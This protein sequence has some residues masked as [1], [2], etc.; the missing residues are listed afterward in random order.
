MSIMITDI[1]NDIKNDF[2]INEIN[3]KFPSINNNK[4][5]DYQYVFV[6]AK[7]SYYKIFF[8]ID[9]Y[10]ANNF[11]LPSDSLLLNINAPSFEV[12]DLTLVRSLDI[13]DINVPNIQY[14]SCNVYKTSFSL[15]ISNDD[16][17]VGSI[18]RYFDLN[19]SF[20]FNPNS[21]KN[22][23]GQIGVS[24]FNEFINEIKLSKITIPFYHQN[25]ILVNNN[26]Y[27]E[28]VV[29]VESNSN[30]KI[31]L[32]KKN[33]YIELINFEYTNEPIKKLFSINFDETY[34]LIFKDVI[35]NLNYSIDNQKKNSKLQ[36]ESELGINGKNILFELNN[37]ET[38]FDES[39]KEI[40]F[41]KGNNGISFPFNTYGEYEIS[42]VMLIE[43]KPTI[44]KITNKF[45]YSFVNNNTNFIVEDLFES[46]INYEE[47]Y[48]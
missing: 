10:I 9:V 25:K 8:E 41:Q 32:T 15:D 16:F 47:I 38:Y 11:F 23:D 1:F 42:F 33:F 40:L 3:S 45:N 28:H 26:N 5:I 12:N 27:Y 20:G 34:N 43:N 14:D 39:K 2:Y 17:F 44:Y 37:Y 7:Y 22:E 29:S 18:D 31:N 30:N 4:Y 6:K 35:L 19:F 13:V 36:F 24:N 46:L 21:L 48:I